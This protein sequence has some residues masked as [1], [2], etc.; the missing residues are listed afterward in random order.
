M[1]STNDKIVCPLLKK[2]CVKQNCTWFTQVRGTNPNTGEPVDEWQCAVNLI[3]VLLIENS[4]Q[5][6]STAAAVES[7]RNE[8]VVRTDNLNS[9]IVGLVQH[10]LGQLPVQPVNV[11]LIESDS[12]SSSPNFEQ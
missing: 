12:S 3:P 6:R 1:F 11:G 7:F 10:S 9:A 5:Q 8:S 4:K 2:P